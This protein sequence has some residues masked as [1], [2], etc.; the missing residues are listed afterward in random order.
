MLYLSH[1]LFYLRKKSYNI[2]TGTMKTIIIFWL[3][4]LDK[5]TYIFQ[6]L[7]SVYSNKKKLI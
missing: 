4:N 5:N 7:L 6:I 3:L 1:S 2:N